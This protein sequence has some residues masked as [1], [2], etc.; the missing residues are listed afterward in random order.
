MVWPVI[1]DAS[2]DSRN[3][4]SEPTSSGRPSRLSGYVAA[5]S[6]SRPS[7]RAPANLVFT[8]A[9]ATALTRISGASS[10]ASSIVTRASIAFVAPYQPM[11]GD[12]ARPATDDRLTTEPPCSPIHASRQA[13][14]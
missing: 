4:T 11:P 7:Y 1:H 8:T 12:G 2:S 6:A 9:G 10:T 13:F 5:T 3:H 14:T